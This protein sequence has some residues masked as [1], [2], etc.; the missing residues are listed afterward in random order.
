[1]VPLEVN[2]TQVSFV[3]RFLCRP[4]SERVLQRGASLIIK[5]FVVKPDTCSEHNGRSVCV[6]MSVCV[7]HLPE[8]WLVVAAALESL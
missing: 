8:I 4:T 6:C 1:M 5:C 7:S 2:Q 3:E